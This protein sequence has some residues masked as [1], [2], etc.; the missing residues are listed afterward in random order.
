MKLIVFIV[1]TEFTWLKNTDLPNLLQA[2]AP[3]PGG[4]ASCTRE[5]RDQGNTIQH[6]ILRSQDK[7]G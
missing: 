1:A 6:N 5:W 3:Q 2:K 7:F 4:G